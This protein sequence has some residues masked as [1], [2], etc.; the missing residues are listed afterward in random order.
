MDL[1]SAISFERAVFWPSIINGVTTAGLYGMIAVAMV[2][3]FRISRTVAF[4]H[5]GLVMGG[6]LLFW[7]LCS[8]NESDGMASAAGVN[9][10][11]VGG[12]SGY[13]THRPELPMWPTIFG[14]MAAG[15]AIAALYGMV[16]TSS[17]MSGYPKV[18]LTNF[19][20]ALMM[21]LVGLLFQYNKSEN[22]PVASPFG[23]GKFHMGIQVVTIHQLMTL[24]LLA[25]IVVGFTILLQQTRFGIYV[26]AIADNVEASKLVGV[27]IG[28]VGTSV[29]AFSGAVSTLGGVLLGNYIGTDTT[30]I[31]FVFLRALIVCVLGAFASIPLALAGAIVLA[32]LDSMLKSDLFGTVDVGLREVIVVA[33]LFGVVILIDRFGKKG[34]SVLAH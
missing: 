24:I 3:S 17:K 30:A 12:S 9:S 7:Y 31:L 26:R 14:L 5:G 19:S 2:L 18:T 27:P 25:V 16:V 34:S 22:E 10:S 15:A 33:I 20:L 8:P 4:L 13:F 11:L 6:T 29:Y 23:A 1:V 21:I 28:T 32:V